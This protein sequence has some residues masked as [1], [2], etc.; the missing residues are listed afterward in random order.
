MLSKSRVNTK[1]ANR[2]WLKSVPSN[3]SGFKVLFVEAVITFLFD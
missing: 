3:L 1:K 2:K